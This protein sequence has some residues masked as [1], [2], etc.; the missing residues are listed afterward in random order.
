MSEALSGGEGPDDLH[1]GIIGE[2]T[3]LVVGPVLDRVGDEDPGGIEPEGRS[4]RG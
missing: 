2:R 3:H 1:D 4:L